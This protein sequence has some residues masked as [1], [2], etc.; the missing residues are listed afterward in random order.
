MLPLKNSDHGGCP[1]LLALCF[2]R[3]EDSPVAPQI[4]S[5]ARDELFSRKSSEQ[6]A[7]YYLFNSQCYFLILKV[8]LSYT[9]IIPY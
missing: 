6:F 3:P 2:T 4:A 7:P 1:D 5:V 9:Y 8:L